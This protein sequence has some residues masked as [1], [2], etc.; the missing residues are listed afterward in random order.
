MELSAEDKE[1]LDLTAE[2]LRDLLPAELTRAEGAVIDNPDDDPISFL[3]YLLQE[4]FSPW[5]KPAIR[6]PFNSKFHFEL[7]FAAKIRKN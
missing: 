4:C 5:E 3:G 6:K 1:M 2:K 7:R